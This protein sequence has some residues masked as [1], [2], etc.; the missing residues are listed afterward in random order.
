MSNKNVNFCDTNPCVVRHKS[1]KAIYKSTKKPVSKALQKRISHMAVPPMFNEF[2][3]SQDPKSRI[4]AVWLDSKGRKQYLYHENWNSSQKDKKYNRMKKFVKQLPTFWR[5]INRDRKST[6]IKIQTIANM[7]L[8]VR[9]THIRVGNEKYYQE[10]GSVGLT[11]LRKCHIRFQNQPKSSVKLVFKGKSHME[12]ELTITNPNVFRFLKRLT[13]GLKPNDLVFPTIQPTDL[14]QYLQS[15]IGKPFTVKD[16]R[17]IAANSIFIKTISRLPITFPKK[18]ITQALKETAR[19]L[20]HKP[21]T[22]KKS[23]VSTNLINIYTTNPEKFNRKR[24]EQLLN[25]A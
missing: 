25:L 10:N 11:T 24:L 16:F 4:Q 12:H 22:S 17:T 2:W 5:R 13:I 21:S 23:Y 1:G 9:D 15:I 7:F 3:V 14:N 6:D 8:I 19:Q 18:S 20:G